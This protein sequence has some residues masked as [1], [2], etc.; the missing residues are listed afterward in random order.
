MVEYIPC[1]TAPVEHWS[2]LPATGLASRNILI[3]KNIKKPTGPALCVLCGPLPAT[4]LA[5]RKIF[6]EQNIKTG[7]A[8]CVLCGY[9]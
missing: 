9:N 8:L 4:R 3:E 2:L 6:T 7:P 5:S 1:C